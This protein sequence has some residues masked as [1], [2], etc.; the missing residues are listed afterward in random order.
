MKT[1]VRIAKNVRVPLPGKWDALLLPTLFVLNI[2]TFSGWFQLSDVAT[3]PW[4]LL[5]RF[6]W[7]GCTSFR[8]LARQGATD[9]FVT[10][11]TR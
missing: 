2:F 5:M 11:S 1:R 6:V 4:L 10:Q 3:K 7:A 9:Y 8:W